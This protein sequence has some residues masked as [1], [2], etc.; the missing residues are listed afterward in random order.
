[1]GD[2]RE[3][4]GA[5]PIRDVVGG[6]DAVRTDVVVGSDRVA[7]WC[8]EDLERYVDREALL[9]ADDPPE[10]PYWAYC[11]CGARVLAERVPRNA[12]RVIELG[13]GL[14]LPGLIAA[15]RGADVV[16]TDQ[17]APPLAFVAASLAANGLVARGCVVADLGRPAW[18][19]AFDLVLASEVL[20]DRAA[21]VRIATALRD[22]LAPGGQALLADGHRIDTT[23]FYAVAEAAGLVAVREDVRVVEEGLPTTITIA[24]LRVA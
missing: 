9:R 5:T 12:G 15:R 17:L 11:W 1:M 21:F 2:N 19:A 6:F 22:M 23:D 14:G 24:T 8:V 16:F 18:R 13:C 10:P 7:L 3:T 4:G 20:Y